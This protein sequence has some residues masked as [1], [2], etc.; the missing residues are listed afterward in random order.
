MRLTR[1]TRL[2]I[3]AVGI[4]YALLGI[5]AYRPIFNGIYADDG[6]SPAVILQETGAYMMLLVVPLILISAINT[7]PDSDQK[8]T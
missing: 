3:N 8:P 5:A 7:A 1:K 4:I 6:T 2:G